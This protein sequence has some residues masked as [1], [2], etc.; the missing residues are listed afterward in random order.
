MAGTGERSGALAIIAGRDL[1]P[2]LVAEAR[3]KEGRDYLVIGFRG[4]APDWIGE[5]PHQLHEFERPGAL[6]AAL[7]AA[8]CDSVVFAGA[9]ERPRLRPWRADARAA[10]L[11]PRARSLMAGGDDALLAGVAEVFEEEGLR[12][13]GVQDCVS[14]LTV[15][16]G[17][18]GRRAPREQARRDAAL[19]AQILEALGRFD[20]GQAAVVAGGRCLGIEAAEGTDELIERVGGLSAADGAGVLV[21][22]AKPG[23][24]R[25]FDLPAIGPRTVRGA[26]RAGLEGVAIEAGAVLMLER[27]ATVAAADA[28]D[29]FLWSAARDALLP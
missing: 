8:G 12:V 22:M 10:A 14:G 26:A 17:A 9:L 23:Q 19:G 6:F 3:R 24:D 29:L 7:R 21:K 4:A 15:S 18:L 25:R 11:L 2:R 16:P 1:L 20:V 13:V 5:H 28:A 27:E